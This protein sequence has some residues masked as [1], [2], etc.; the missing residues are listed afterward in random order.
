[1][2]TGY[3]LPNAT[4]QLNLNDEK[5]KATINGH[6]DAKCQSILFKISNNQIHFSSKLLFILHLS[7]PSYSICNQKKK[8]KN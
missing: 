8:K 2:A 7:I 1:M 6:I 4:L 5:C 3:L